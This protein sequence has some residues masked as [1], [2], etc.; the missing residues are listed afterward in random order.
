MVMDHLAGTGMTGCRDLEGD[1]AFD[2]RL[3]E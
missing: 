1:G 3:A 2:L